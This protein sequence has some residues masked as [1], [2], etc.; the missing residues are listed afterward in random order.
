MGT[1]GGVAI[2]WNSDTVF[3]QTH[4]IGQFS[5][6]AKVS[7]IGAQDYFWLTTVY[8]P[9]YEIRNDDFL[10]EITRVAPHP[11]EAWLINGDFN[12]IYEARDK[13]NSNINRRIIGK[14]RAAIDAGGLREIKCKN[15]RFTWSNERRNPTLVS[16][17]KFFCTI[18][19]E[20][21][22]PTHLLH[23][24]STSCSDH[25]PLLLAAAAAPRRRAR[26]RFESFW[27]RHPHFHETVDRAW[28]R[29]MT[30]R[31]AFARLN[32]KMTRVAKDLKIWSKSLFSDARLQLHLASEIVLRLDIAQESRPLSDVEFHLR[33]ALK[34]RILGLAA[35]ERAQKRQASRIT[36][37][38]AGDAPTAFF[39]AKISSRAHKNFIHALLQIQGGGLDNP[40]TQEE[41][42]LAIKSSPAERSPGPDGFSGTFFRSCW[43]LIKSDIMAAF[44]QFYNLA[45]RN[46]AMLNTALVALLPKK[47]GRPPLVIIGLLV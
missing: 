25:C 29:P 12:I 43:A 45:G 3:V 15:R 16:I 36:W 23:A 47:M 31:C 37:L 8:G 22:F 6:T 11:G 10:A 14:F 28:N 13:N 2:F 4:A 1:R 34:L 26:F 5:I 24:A 19:W 44:S 21:L 30:E 46:F 41:V 35:V 33:K 18:A 9:A 39:Q 32:T 17:D 38:R 7:I 40:F 42:W 27:P 20:S